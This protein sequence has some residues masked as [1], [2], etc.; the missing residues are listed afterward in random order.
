[1]LGAPVRIRSVTLALA[2][3]YALMVE[4]AD[5]LVPGTSAARRPGSTPDR[6]TLTEKTYFAAC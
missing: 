5:T 2:G 4:Q 1:M 3:V 6:R